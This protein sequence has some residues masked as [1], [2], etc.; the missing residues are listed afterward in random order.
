LPRAV[1]QAAFPQGSGVRRNAF[2]RPFF[3]HR[4][5]FGSGFPGYW[6]AWPYD[7][8][9]GDGYTGDNAA[10]G[11]GEPYAPAPS[12]YSGG[13]YPPATSTPV[14]KQVIYVVPYRPGCETQTETLPWRNGSE[15]SIRIVRC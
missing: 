3:R 5:H 7:Y 10:L 1:P 6:G 13:P 12:P 11:Y 8:G 2:G 15:H 4:R 14:S 9:Y